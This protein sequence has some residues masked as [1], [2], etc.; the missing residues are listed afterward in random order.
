MSFFLLKRKDFIVGYLQECFKNQ[1]GCVDLAKEIL[2]QTPMKREFS[3]IPAAFALKFW[4]IQQHHYLISIH[5]L[6]ML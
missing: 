2:K 5:F 3:D 1:P 4:S 6:N